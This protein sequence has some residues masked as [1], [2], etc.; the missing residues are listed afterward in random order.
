MLIINNNDT[1]SSIF[2]YM[3]FAS[4]ITARQ[5]QVL[6]LSALQLANILPATQCPWKN[7]GTAGRRHP[8]RCT[9][10]LGWED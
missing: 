9:S 8:I 5:R 7:V 3:V 2:I 4:H 6:P 1:V 10:A